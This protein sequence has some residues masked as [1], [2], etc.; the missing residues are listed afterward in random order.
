MKNN[1][2]IYNYINVYIYSIYIYIIAIKTRKKSSR[3]FCLN[4][5]SYINSGV[6]DDNDEKN[7]LKTNK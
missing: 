4:E 2:N 5:I 6:D 7:E 3:V 1:K